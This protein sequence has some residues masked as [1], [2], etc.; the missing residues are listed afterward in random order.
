MLSEPTL[1]FPNFSNYG[2]QIERELGHNRS[3][4]RVT[5]LATEINTGQSV[6]VKQFQFAR[7]GGNWSEYQSYERE[8]QVL[9][10]LDSPQIPR[11]LDSFQTPTG[12]CMVQEYKNAPSL[13]SLTRLT[14]HKA[15]QIAIAVLEILKYLQN[16]IPPVIHRDLKPENILV[17]DVG[18]VFL[19]DFG[20]ARAG[21][22]EVAASSVVKGT[23]GFMPPE[24][25]FNRQITIASDLY[26]LGA[27][28]ICLLLGT[29]ST[30]VGS[31]MDDAGRIHFRSRLSQ[32]SSAFLDWLEKMVEPNYKKRYPTAKV[33]LNELV[34][35]EVLQPKKKSWMPIITSFAGLGLL[36]LGYYAV[37]T[38][39]S[40]KEAVEEVETLSTYRSV[41]SDSLPS[42][43]E[44]IESIQKIE[45]A[46]TVYFYL[47]AD[48][49]EEEVYIGTCRVIAPGFRL[50]YQGSFPLK[51]QNSR[52][53]TWCTYSFNSQDDKPGTWR[54]EFLIGEELIASKTLEVIDRP[55]TST[56]R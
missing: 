54:F 9:R 50:K 41:I 17:D 55:G 12:F 10:E 11:Y 43:R 46:R 2:Y 23:L 13:S 26:S 27:T 22:G 7:T 18:N 38:S 4:G 33:A 6:V 29:P 47:E 21:G 5:Y 52:L 48:R 31:L 53:E 14:P 44:S 24:Q 19:V 35:I 36:G 56:I 51:T 34:S 25:M 45:L 15:K 39:E 42:D 8:I 32:L 3:G 1:T 28:I 40:A 20:F 49:L 37:G 16:R 30:E